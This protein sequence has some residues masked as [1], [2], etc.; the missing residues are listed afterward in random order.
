MKTTLGALAAVGLLL[1]LLALGHAWLTRA[2]LFLRSRS[3]EGVYELSLT[4]RRVFPYFQG[5]EIEAVM[6]HLPTGARRVTPADNRDQ[7]EDAAACYSRIAWEAQGALLLPGWA[8][9]VR[10]AR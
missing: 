2:E 5:V 7:W 4:R 10:V 1:V 3:P 9:P 8:G 6:V